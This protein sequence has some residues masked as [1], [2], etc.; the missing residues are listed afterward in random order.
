MQESNK[1]DKTQ[2]L[3]EITRRSYEKIR[4]TRLNY[5]NNPYSF[6]D[7]RLFQ[8]GFNDDDEE[9][10]YPT[11][12][13]VQFKESDMQE[14]LGKWTL[15]PQIILHPKILKK[16]WNSVMIEEFDNAVFNAFKFIEISVRKIGKFND[17]DLGVPLMRKAFDPDDGP[18]TDISLP[19]SERESLSHLF[20]G[21]IGTYKNPHS[22]RDV[23]IDFK[24]CFEGL[25]LASHLMNILDCIEKRL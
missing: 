14:L 7:I 4:I 20:S 2:I 25:L 13:G 19:K 9:V 17:S 6:I 15:V 16:S 22:H 10:Y 5:L 3:S 12:K 1:L 8:R 11:K 21:A 24:E 18:L 23:D